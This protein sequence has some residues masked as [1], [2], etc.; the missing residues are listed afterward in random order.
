MTKKTPKKAKLLNSGLEA[1]VV[2]TTCFI[3][4]MIAN[5]FGLPLFINLILAFTA[6]GYSSYLM[7]FAAK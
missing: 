2:N 1:V 5:Y 3:L 4:I 6:I 7:F